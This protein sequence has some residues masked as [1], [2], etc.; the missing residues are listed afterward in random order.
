MY[1][2]SGLGMIDDEKENGGEAKGSDEGW[3]HGYMESLA[4]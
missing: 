4:L 1:F 3:R 2:I